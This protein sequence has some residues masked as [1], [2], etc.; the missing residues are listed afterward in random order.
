MQRDFPRQISQ[1]QQMCTETKLRQVHICLCR[2]LVSVIAVII[3][4]SNE[5]AF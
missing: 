3:N 1:S 2:N 5:D 4:H